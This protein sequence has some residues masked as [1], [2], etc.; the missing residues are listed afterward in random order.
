MG[1]A[2]V[3]KEVAARLL[4]GWSQRAAGALRHRQ[5]GA[6]DARARRGGIV[7]RRGRR[8]ISSAPACS[9]RRMAARLFL[10]EI[11][12]M[13][14]A[15]QARILRVLT[16]QSFTRVGGTPHG[17]GRRPRRLGDR[18]RPDDGDRRGAVPRGP[19]LPAQRRARRDPAA[20]RAARGHPRAGRAFRRALCQRAP[21]ADARSRARRAW[22]RCKATNGRA[23]SASCA[24]SSNAPII[25]AP[26]DRIGRIDLDLLPAEVLGEP[27]ESGRRAPTR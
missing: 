19:L 4:H 6:D 9:N 15:T 22:S 7:R 27:G 3:G 18:A 5:R 14:I 12:D 25:L 8:A 21:R 13:P 24:M 23:M 17:Q 16:D 11:A 1:A 20:D 2:G 10:D 26:G